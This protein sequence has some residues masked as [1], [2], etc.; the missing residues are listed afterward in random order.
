MTAMQLL[1]E[2]IGTQKIRLLGIGFSRLR[3]ETEADVDYGF[4]ITGFDI[5][6]YFT[7]R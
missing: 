5:S 3:K 2:F 1:P 7:C 4:C 6:S